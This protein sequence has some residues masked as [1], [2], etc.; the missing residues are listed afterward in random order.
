MIDN[1][2]RGTCIP[3]KHG[4]VG[5]TYIRDRCPSKLF[6]YLSY[7]GCKPSLACE[8]ERGR[9]RALRVPPFCRNRQSDDH[10]DRDKGRN[11]ATPRAKDER[12]TPQAATTNRVWL[13]CGA[14]PPLVATRR[15][16]AALGYLS[17]NQSLRKIGARM[18]RDRARSW[19]RS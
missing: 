9:E 1:E 15:C 6:C 14:S 10:C 17:A 8:R 18:D 13:L 2:T 5:I 7:L 16:S 11:N 4:G 3:G 19:L 12:D